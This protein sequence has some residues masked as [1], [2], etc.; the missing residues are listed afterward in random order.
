MNES[1]GK[2]LRQAGRR[3]SRTHEKPVEFRRF[4]I[5]GATLARAKGL[6]VGP[7]NRGFPGGEIPRKGRS[8]RHRI[9]REG[10]SRGGVLE[11]RTGQAR[12]SGWTMH[13]YHAYLMTRARR[14][15]D[16]HREDLSTVTQHCS[17]GGHLLPPVTLIAVLLSAGCPGSYRSCSPSSFP[18]YPARVV[19][20]ISG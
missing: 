14:S 3:T 17:Y 2:R 19:W 13:V 8:T 11:E 7:A 10:P 4:G 16:R 5:P 15:T 1:G 18:V 20:G 9:E 6:G 12:T